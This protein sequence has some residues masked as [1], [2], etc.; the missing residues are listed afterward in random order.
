MT[1]E[2]LDGMIVVM[3]PSMMMVAWM[4]WRATPVDPKF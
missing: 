1:Q 4:V 3:L 2:F